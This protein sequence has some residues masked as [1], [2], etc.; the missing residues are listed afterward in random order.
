MNILSLIGKGIGMLFGGSS[1]GKSAVEVVAEK[2]DEYIYTA[3][4]K[5]A[6]SDKRFLKDSEDTVKLM[7]LDKPSPYDTWIDRIKRLERPGWG[8]YFFGGFAGWWKFPDLTQ[9]AE[10]TFWTTLFTI[11]FTALFGGRA[12]FKDLAGA[13]AGIL[14]VKK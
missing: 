8:L 9:M 14:K 10:I 2:A 11:Y 3:E 4:E 1:S 7:E 13:I 5:E 6:S 12:I